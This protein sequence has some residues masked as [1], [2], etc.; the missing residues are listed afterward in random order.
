[1]IGWHRSVHSLLSF[2]IRKLRIVLLTKLTRVLHIGRHV[3]WLPVQHMNLLFHFVDVFLSA[4]DH[5]VSHVKDLS[6]LLVAESLLSL[7]IQLKRL[8]L[9]INILLYFVTDPIGHM[10]VAHYF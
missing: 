2:I 6:F 3:S 4:F 5:F 7:L 1:M 8:L 9:H 10:E